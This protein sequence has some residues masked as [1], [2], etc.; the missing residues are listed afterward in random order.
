MD[1]EEVLCG[2]W[3]VGNTDQATL[4]YADKLLYVFTNAVYCS[5]SLVYG[6]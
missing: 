3:N 2:F 5:C 6:R 1:I 4:G